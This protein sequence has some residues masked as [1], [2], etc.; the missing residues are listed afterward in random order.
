MQRCAV[1]MHT[2]AESQ[3]FRHAATA[4]PWLACATGGTGLGPCASRRGP[5]L[6]GP[7]YYAAALHQPTSQHLCSLQQRSAAAAAG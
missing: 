4:Q 3:Y 2:P 5:R 7:S 1:R 6:A